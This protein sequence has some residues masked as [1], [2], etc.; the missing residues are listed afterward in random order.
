MCPSPA[1]HVRRGCRAGR[2]RSR[3]ARRAAHGTRPG[4]PRRAGDG[5]RPPAS[6]RRSGTYEALEAPLTAQLR[7]LAFEQGFEARRVL[8][9]LVDLHIGGRIIPAMHPAAAHAAFALD[10]REKTLH[11]RAQLREP[12]KL[13]LVIDVVV[14]TGTTVR[15]SAPFSVGA[16]STTVPPLSSWPG[17]SVTRAGRRGCAMRRFTW[18]R[19]CARATISWPG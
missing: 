18:P 3:Q 2:A 11:R 6:Q 12:H 1:D 15:S 4:W 17:T 16:T 13:H 10:E 5:A 7:A 19:Y 14:Q 9:V 8:H